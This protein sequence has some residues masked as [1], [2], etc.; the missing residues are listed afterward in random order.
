MAL[1]CV[2]CGRE[3]SA[4][5]TTRHISQLTGMQSESAADLC[6]AGAFPGAY[7]GPDGT[8]WLIP[9]RAGSTS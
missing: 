7:K 4:Y 9:F 1:P 3:Q 2:G 5:L 8:S 6:Q